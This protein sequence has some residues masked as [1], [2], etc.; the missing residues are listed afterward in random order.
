M[1]NA[2]VLA[3]LPIVIGMVVS[4]GAQAQ[5]PANR[6]NRRERHQ[7]IRIRAGLAQGDLTCREA[8][9]L[10]RNHRMIRRTEVSARADGRIDRREQRRLHRMQ[11]RANGRIYWQRHPDSYRDRQ[12][13]LN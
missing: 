7:L 13:R 1:R 11:V 9:A 5:D 4:I 2:W 10:L 12:S 6:M 3:V 8:A